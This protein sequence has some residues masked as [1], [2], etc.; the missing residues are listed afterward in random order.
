MA[1]LLVIL[2]LL[3]W[4]LGGYF[5]VGIIL[6]ILGLALWFLAP[7]PYSYRSTRGGP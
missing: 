7:G 6:I 5:L 2:G 4:L 1:L 3:L